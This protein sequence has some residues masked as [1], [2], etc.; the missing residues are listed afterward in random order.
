V[1][2]CR[3]STAAL[4]LASV[5]SIIIVPAAKGEEVGDLDINMPNTLDDAFVGDRGSAEL[6]GAARYDHGRRGDT[7]RFFPRLQYVPL[8]GLQLS[9]GLPYSIGSGPDAN[10]GEVNLDALYNLNRETRW[11]PAFAV[12][13][14]VNAPVG[15]G[16]HGWDLQLWGIASKT[17]DSGPAQRRLH[18]NLVWM[19]H[20]D[21]TGDERQDRY[22]VTLGYSQLLEQRTALV[23]NI[24][25]QTQERGERPATIIE[26]GL[27]HQISQNVT[28]GGA[29][30]T[31]IGRDSPRFRAIVSVQFSLGGG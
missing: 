9:V 30:G 31:G 6:Q 24:L 10:Q 8:E 16:G 1:P 14:E 23:A 29:L 5:F 15:P 27:R 18:L 13:T 11:L 7:V 12:S 26:A 3:L 19:H 17:V 25:R 20:F 22:R 4:I 28:L 2:N 21:P